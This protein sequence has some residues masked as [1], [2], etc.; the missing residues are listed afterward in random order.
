M[1]SKIATEIAATVLTTACAAACAAIPAAHV[2]PSPIKP[3]EL[4]LEAK[5]DKVFAQSSKVNHSKIT[6]VN[7]YGI[8]LAADLYIPKNAQ[9]K[10]PAIAVSGPFGAV[11]EQSSGL[12]A[13]TLAERGY[14]TLPL[15]L[16]LPE[17]AAVIPVM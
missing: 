3:A 8:T 11:K 16:H 6:F 14:L 4:Q 7:R 15:I 10:L 12:Y 1:T 9:G 13:Q 17:K 2:A 5:W